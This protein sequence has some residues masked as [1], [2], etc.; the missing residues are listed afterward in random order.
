MSDTMTHRNANARGPVGISR[1]SLMLSSAAAL[2]LLA[3]PARAQQATPDASPVSSPASS[4]GTRVIST[5]MGD[6][7]ITGTPDRVVAIEWNLVEYVL[8]LGVQPV[9]IADIEGYEQWVTT[10]IELASDVADVGLRY[11]PS[12]ES[13][14]AA[15]PDLILGTTD[16]DEAIYDQL[17]EIAPTLL[18]P[19][20]PTKEGETP[21]EDINETLRTIATALN[22]EAEAT[23]VIEHMKGTLAEGAAAIEE[24]G[25]AGRPFILTQAFTS[26]NVPTLRLFTNESLFGFAL[27]ELGLENAWEGEP[28]PWGFNT[29]TV[30]ALVDVPPETLFFYVVQDDD[31]I[32]EDQLQDD[33]IWTSLPFV[34]EGHTYSLG[35]DTWTFGGHLSVERLV[36]KVVEHLA[37]TE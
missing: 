18:L 5:P 7:T 10:P 28:D 15:E 22:R 17:S 13:I 33:P 1:R 31:N 11:E 26:E 36:T 24:A 4:A 6:V 27:T 30:E 9:A 12:L 8:A 3:V 14:A 19:P 35:G 16:R 2:G 23:R 21:I 29:V 34:Q 37:P 32:F 25:L 20:Y